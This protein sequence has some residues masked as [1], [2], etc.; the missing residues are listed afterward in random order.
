MTSVTR[1]PGLAGQP[2]DGPHA[3]DVPTRKSAR[4]IL[5]DIQQSSTLVVPGA[6][7][8]A[9]L[10]FRRFRGEEDF[11]AMAAVIDAAKDADGLE[12]ATSEEEV[13]RTYRHLVNSEPDQDML[14]VE[15][16]GELIGYGRVFWNEQNDGTRLYQQFA[17]IKPEWRGKG[18]RRAM[19]R[20][21]E[22]RLREIAAAHPSSGPKLYEAWAADTE[23]HWESLLI[24]FGYKAVRWGFQMVRS[25]LE[26]IPDLPVPEGLEVRPVE[27][28]HYEPI[29]MALNE[30]FQD[31]W[32]AAEFHAEW[33]EA[34]QES[35]TFDPSLWQVAWDGDEIAG[36]VLPF[37]DQ[38]ENQL[39]GRKRG[40]TEYICTRRPWRRRGLARALIARGLQAIKERGM[41]EAALGVDTQN[42]H[43]ALRLYESMGFRPARRSTSYR[44]ALESERRG[45]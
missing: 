4:M 32:G 44:K 12:W 10:A 34:W 2:G 16:D 41:E 25:D 23:Q 31:S 24:D 36:T 1:Q 27:P 17:H 29:R 15:V 30:A 39:Y 9:G 7:A 11:A 42:L 8:I 40:M 45:K 21:G 26:E 22:Q 19:V 28:A 3:V 14:M 20:H 43:G 18:I 37:I 13:A 38:E 6:P 33:L 5:T 35:P